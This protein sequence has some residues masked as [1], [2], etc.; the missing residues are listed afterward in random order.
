MKIAG[1]K[2]VNKGQNRTMKRLVKTDGVHCY[3]SFPTERGDRKRV[4]AETI[5]MQERFIW[6]GR[7]RIRV[8]NRN[9]A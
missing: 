5:Q 6:W 7:G 9:A 1:L 3:N 8:Q 2:N 4:L